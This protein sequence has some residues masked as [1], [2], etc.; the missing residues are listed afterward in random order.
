MPVREGG[1]GR[2]SAPLGGDKGRSPGRG[3]IAGAAKTP[4]GKPE[5]RV[6]GSPREVWSKRPCRSSRPPAPRARCR[7]PGKRSRTV[8]QDQYIF[9]SGVVKKKPEGFSAR[10][11]GPEEIAAG[12][13]SHPRPQGVVSCRLASLRAFVGRLRPGRHGDR[14]PVSGRLRPSPRRGSLSRSSGGSRLLRLLGSAAAWRPSPGLCRAT[15]RD[16]DADAWFLAQ[17]RA[18]GAVEHALERHL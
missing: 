11:W 2:P 12:R 17:R 14:P 4:R 15:R 3:P 10:G 13:T 7:P 16:G 8:S 9:L 5:T 1:G 6:A 18:R